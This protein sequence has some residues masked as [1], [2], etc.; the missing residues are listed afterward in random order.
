MWRDSLDENGET[1]QDEIKG[2][3]M[4]INFTR[5]FFCT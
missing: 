2:L 4:D 1:R 3:M 5:L